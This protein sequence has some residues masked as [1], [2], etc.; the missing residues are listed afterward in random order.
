MVD[1]SVQMV[2]FMI[3]HELIQ[4]KQLG[5]V[6]SVPGYSTHCEAA[7]LTPLVNWEEV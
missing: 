3:L 6:S 4:T 1:E 2:E 5:V 7:W